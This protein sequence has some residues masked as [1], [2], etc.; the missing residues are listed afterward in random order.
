MRSAGASAWRFLVVGLLNTALGYMLFIALA[1]VMPT[2]FAYILSYCTGIGFAVVANLRWTFRRKLS[3]RA[4]VLSGLVYLVTMTA[5]TFLIL[6]LDQAGVDVPIIGVAVTVMGIA[7]NFI[8]M[9]LISHRVTEAP[10]RAASER[11]S[12]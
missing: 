10:G 2:A 12:T 3:V 11:Q 6:K 7:M 9:R 4:V 8:G 1:W 5:G